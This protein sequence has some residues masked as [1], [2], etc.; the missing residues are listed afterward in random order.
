MRGLGFFPN[1]RAPKVIWCGARQGKSELFALA[2]LMEEAVA[3]L[4][5]VP[6]KQPFSPHLTLARIPAMRGVEAM[7]SVVKSHQEASLGEAQV[8]SITFYKSTLTPDGPIYEALHQWPLS[9]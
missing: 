3:P 8:E 2:K 9:V 7:A 4:G 1:V 5:F 6:D